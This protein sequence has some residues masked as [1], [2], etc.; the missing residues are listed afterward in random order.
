[1]FSCENIPNE[2]IV[3]LD[4]AEIGA[5]I[6]ISSV[7]LPNNVLPTITDRDFVI[8][9]VG[10]PTILVEPVKAEETVVEGETPTEGTPEGTAETAE[11]KEKSA[12]EKTKE[13]SAKPTDEKT[14]DKPSEKIKSENKETKKK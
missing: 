5:S 14:K 9:T 12:D 10:S 1:M 6:K 2:I 3:D 8:A 7:K 4:N 13:K 11:G